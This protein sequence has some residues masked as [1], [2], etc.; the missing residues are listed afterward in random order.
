M[1]QDYVSE[2]DG[3]IVHHRPPSTTYYEANTMDHDLLHAHPR[4]LLQQRVRSGCPA[5]LAAPLW[6]HRQPTHHSQSTCACRTARGSVRMHT[7]ARESIFAR[8]Q[9]PPKTSEQ[10]HLAGAQCAWDSSMG[11]R[12]VIAIMDTGCDLS[13][14]DLAPNVWVNKGE[15]PGNG[16]DDDGNGFI[17]DVYGWNFGDGGADL[18]DLTGHGTHVASVAAGAGV[19]RVSG[20][21]PGARIMCLKV[22]DGDGRLFA[23]Y[24]FQA[25]QYALDMGAHIVVNSFSNTYWSVPAGQARA[26]P[27]LRCSTIHHCSARWRWLLDACLICTWFRTLRSVLRLLS[28]YCIAHLMGTTERRL[29]SAEACGPD[30][31]VQG[32]AGHARCGGSARAR[33]GRQRASRQRRAVRRGLRQRAVQRAAAERHRCRRD[34]PRADAVGGGRRKPGREG[35]RLQL[36]RRDRGHERARRAHRGRKD[37][38]GRR[39]RER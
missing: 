13:H 35:K 37:E 21:A 11:E 2:T 27:P 19:S 12:V 9:I 8:V 31:R 38:Q 26:R 10:W 4:A 39:G 22:Q 30:A 6:S 20:V 36:W 32:T 3:G 7:Q 15:I 33:C 16:V 1:V 14:P 5:V 23:S 25:Y 24:M 18:T 17:D 34:G 29:C 28:S